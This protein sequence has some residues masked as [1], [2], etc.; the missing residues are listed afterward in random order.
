MDVMPTPHFAS[1][2]HGPR[3]IPLDDPAEAFHEASRLYPSMAPARLDVATR[4]ASDPE[5]QAVTRRAGRLHDHREPVVLPA[6][7]PLIGSLDDLLARRRSGKADALRPLGAADL[8]AVLAACYA[9]GDRGKRPVPS[10]G[11][12]Y[13]L[14]LYVVVAD[15]NGIERGVYHFHPFRVGLNRLAP[16]NWKALRDALA[17][18]DLLERTAAL[19][20]VTAT[21]A[22]TRFKYGP[23]GYRFALLEAGHLGQNAVLAATGLGLPALPIGGFFDRQL[24]AIVGA[25]GL[26]EATIYAVALGGAA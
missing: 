26:G 1:L 17:A 2:V 4:L 11:G 5:L 19:L 12:L 21:F 6:P 10:G 24:D 15:V 14:E 16:L 8:S 20:V 18:P 7:T 22:R 25:D 13:P 23:R 3:G 9:S